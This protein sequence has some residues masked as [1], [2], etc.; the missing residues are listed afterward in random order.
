[1]V[2]VR[3]DRGEAHLIQADEKFKRYLPG[4]I[5]LRHSLDVSQHFAQSLQQPYQF[6]LT[7][8]SH[9]GVSDKSKWA[10][11]LIAKNIQW[12]SSS[13][14]YSSNVVCSNRISLWE[15]RDCDADLDEGRKVAGQV[16]SATSKKLACSSRAIFARD[17]RVFNL[18]HAIIT[19]ITL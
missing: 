18:E 3:Q 15:S 17:K 6:L 13:I 5:L 8:P 16:S 2:G 11:I 19:V 14:S 12:L 7:N 9:C 4:W 1:M 10:W